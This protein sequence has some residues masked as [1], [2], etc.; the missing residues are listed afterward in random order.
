MS[1]RSIDDLQLTDPLN[2]TQFTYVPGSLAVTTVPSGAT[3]AAM[4]SATWTPLTKTFTGNYAG[5]T[6]RLRFTSTNDIINVTN[7]FFDT[8]ALTATY[9]STSAFF[10][11]MGA[12]AF[13]KGRSSNACRFDSNAACRPR[14]SFR[15]ISAR[16]C[17]R[18]RVRP[19]HRASA[20]T[21]GH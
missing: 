16:P 8:I 12:G 5:Q 15:S 13:P 1:F 6:V 4:W 2:E 17:R 9:C 20:R 21:A 7:F 19:F 14:K 11:S 10:V 3:N 18:N